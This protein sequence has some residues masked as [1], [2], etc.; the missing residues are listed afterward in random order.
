MYL[1]VEQ[2]KKHLNIES[3]FTEDD[4]YLEY[5]IDVATMVVEKHIDISLSA[6]CSEDFRGDSKLPSPL[7]H[8]M[9]FFIAN[10][11]SNRESI[12]SYNNYEL[13]LSYSYILDL[14]KNYKS[15]LVVDE[16]EEK[17]EITEDEETDEEP[18]EEII[19]GEEDESGE[20]N[21]ED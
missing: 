3:D 21:R 5:L 19:G 18:N 13:P 8:T 15:K 6:L 17:E 1:S 2:V 9:L 16:V 20:V 12:A 10:L 11:Y 4:E 7:I 14:F